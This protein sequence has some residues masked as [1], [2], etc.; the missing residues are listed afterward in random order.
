MC[1]IMSNTPRP[2]MLVLFRIVSETL[3]WNVLFLLEQAVSSINEQWC[4][5]SYLSRPDEA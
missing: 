3:E 1:T 4:L 2:S 5:F